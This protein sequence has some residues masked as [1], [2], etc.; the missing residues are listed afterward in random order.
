MAISSELEHLLSEWLPRQSWFPRQ[1]GVLGRVLAS[2]PDV[3]PMSSVEVFHLDLPSGGQV[4]G[5]ESV[6]AVGSTTPGGAE[7]VFRL[8]IPLTYRTEEELS[9]RSH[10]IG[11][12]DDLTLGR[13]WVYDAAA[14]PAYVLTMV[15]AIA[16]GRSFPGNQVNAHR[17]SPQAVDVDDLSSSVAVA[18]ALSSAQVTVSDRANV[19]NVVIDRGLS[20]SVLTVFRVLNAATAAALH[21]PVALTK[22]DSAAVPHV[23]GWMSGR[24]FDG[25]GLE[26]CELPTL[27]LTGGEAEAD[28]AWAQAVR[29]AL[30]VDSGSTASFV[31]TAG[32]IG[33]RIGELHGD[34]AGIFGIVESA[35]AT[36]AW[37]K[38]WQER[39]D[40]AFERS[41]LTLEP[42]RGDLKRHREWLAGL[43]SVGGLQR[44]H[45]DLTLGNVIMAPTAGPRVRNFAEGGD[46]QTAEPKP[47]AFDLVALLRSL[48]YA[49]GYARLKR[50]GALEADEAPLTSGLSPDQLREVT[51]SPEFEWSNRAQNSLLTGYSRG[52]EGAVTLDDPILRA[53]LIDRLLVE[54]VTEL[55]NRPAWLTVPLAA[56][57]LALRGR[58][59]KATPRG[60]AAHRSGPIEPTK[61]TKT[62]RAEAPEEKQ[63][64]EEAQAPVGKKVGKKAAKKHEGGRAFGLDGTAAPV[65]KTQPA[66]DVAGRADVADAR[67][68]GDAAQA[69]AWAVPGDKVSAEDF[70]QR[71]ELQIPQQ[72]EPKKKPK[73]PKKAT[74]AQEKAEEKAADKAETQAQPEPSEPDS[75]SDAQA[76]VLAD[77]P[78]EQKTDKPSGTSS[79]SAEAEP[80]PAPAGGGLGGLVIGDY[81]LHEEDGDYG[82]ETEEEEQP[83]A[84]PKSARNN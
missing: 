35:D 30:E 48:D 73:K 21:M 7:Q 34:L 41:P 65:K 67:S 36:S 76:D 29:S 61:V 74:K 37:I 42:L 17:V 50:T 82:D 72:D 9:L 13:V 4:Y 23:A 8:N 2:S 46:G 80:Q 6:I 51:D 24:W 11:R 26:T 19:T 75:K 52:V 83:P 77:S 31:D 3:T 18:E 33:S 79:D 43:D 45:G 32:A 25:Y 55:R 64:S 53:V 20:R 62:P 16:A 27:M 39:I 5:Y 71:A 81:T 68:E 59:P 54:V 63:A 58:P 44:I 69:S 22:A 57:T 1:Q 56:L 47:P 60:T 49:A 15:G 70:A 40:W 38:K 28:T 14:D 84:Q 10:L 12:I 66:A 78:S